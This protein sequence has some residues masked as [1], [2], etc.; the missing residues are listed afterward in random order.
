MAK[1]DCKCYV[2]SKKNTGKSGDWYYKPMMH[3][4][5]P[6]KDLYLCKDCSKTYFSNHYS[7]KNVKVTLT[8][9]KKEA[10]K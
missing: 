4:G 5:S 3:T 10:K 6:P 7:W 8:K 9:M 1:K 2:C